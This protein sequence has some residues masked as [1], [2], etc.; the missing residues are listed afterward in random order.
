MKNY[1]NG[2]EIPLGL[3]MALAQNRAAMN[4]FAALPA[5]EQQALIKRTH[6][7]RSKEE[8][9]AFVQSLLP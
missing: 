1:A 5:S 4:R 2:P 3:G 8:M 6:G 9:Q 7:I